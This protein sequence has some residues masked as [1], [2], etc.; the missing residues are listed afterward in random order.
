MVNK[1]VI[2][3]L[4]GITNTQKNYLNGFT[5]IYWTLNGNNYNIKIV[6]TKAK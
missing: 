6:D 5:R 1:F 2:L 4:N 3:H